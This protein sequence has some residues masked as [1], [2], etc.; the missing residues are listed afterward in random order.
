MRLLHHFK[1]LLSLCLTLKTLKAKE[2]R[3]EGTETQGGRPEL[4]LHRQVVR[5]KPGTE[6]FLFVLLEA[7]LQLWGSKEEAWRVLSWVSLSG[8]A[9]RI[10]DVKRARAHGDAPATMI[11][12]RS[13]KAGEGTLER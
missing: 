2:P 12:G 8:L 9:W 7:R 4:S 1:A 6:P 13:L 3:L 11:S 10:G 5:K